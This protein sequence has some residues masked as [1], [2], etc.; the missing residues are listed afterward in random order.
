MEHPPLSIAIRM[1]RGPRTQEEFAELLGVTP[2]TVSRWESDDDPEGP[3]VSIS[4]L[5][6]LVGHGLDSTYLLGT[7][8]AE[9]ASPGPEAA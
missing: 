1:I 4:N 7:E 9:Q 2:R 5:R 8:H 3:E 6:L